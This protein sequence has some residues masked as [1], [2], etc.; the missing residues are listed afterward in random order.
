MGKLNLDS[1]IKTFRKNLLSYLYMLE[2]EFREVNAFIN[3]LQ[4]Y[5]PFKLDVCES[6]T[7][8]NAL[9]IAVVI[10]YARNFKTS[11]GFKNIKEVTNVLKQDFTKQELKFHKKIIMLRDEVFAHSDASSND[12]QIYNE[13]IFSHSRKVVRE[14]LEKDE[15]KMLSA[16]V[17][18]IRKQIDSQIKLLK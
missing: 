10:S 7:T 8:Q 14:L 1:L 11:Y 5:N 18:K 6:T 17:G 4:N 12:I 13:G 2:S 16:M 15:L 3:E 9:N